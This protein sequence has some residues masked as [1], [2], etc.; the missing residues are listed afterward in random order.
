MDRDPYE[1][2]GVS[3]SASEDEIK[4]AYRELAKQYHPDRY[5]NNPLAN[6]AQEKFQEIQKAYETIMKERQNGTSGSSYSGYNGYQGYQ[7][8]YQNNYQ[9]SAG[10]SEMNT[11]RSYLQMGRYQEALNLLS[12]INNQNA[13][14]NYYCA[15]AHKGMGNNMEALNYARQAVAMEPNNMQYRQFLNSLSYSGVRYQNTAPVYGGTNADPCDCCVRLW[16]ADSLC[17]CMGG[18]LCS[19]C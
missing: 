10:S 11:V 2:L 4:K 19:C 14:W 16:C 3:R 12:R 9:N 1:V 18:D 8:S 13:L 6:L 5:V 15:V 17:E 7:G